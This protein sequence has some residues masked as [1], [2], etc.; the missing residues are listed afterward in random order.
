MHAAQLFLS[1]TKKSDAIFTLWFNKK[2]INA[3]LY[4]TS[5]GKEGPT[6]A[7]SLVWEYHLQC[8]KWSGGTSYS[9]H[10]WFGGPIFGGPVVP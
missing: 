6:T 8:R 2:A 5:C 3:G 7:P 9:C 1:S 4:G 10:K